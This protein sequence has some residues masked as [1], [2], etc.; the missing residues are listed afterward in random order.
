MLCSNVLEHA[1]LQSFINVCLICKVNN[2]VNCPLF[3]GGLYME[4]CTIL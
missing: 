4:A 2:N 1:L 3:R